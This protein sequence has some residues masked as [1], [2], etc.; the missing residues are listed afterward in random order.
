MEIYAERNGEVEEIISMDVQD[1]QRLM[2]TNPHKFTTGSIDTMQE[3][4]VF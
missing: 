2:A 3:C 1:I 4:V